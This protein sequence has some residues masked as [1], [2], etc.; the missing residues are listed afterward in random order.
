MPITADEE[1]R[2]LLGSVRTIAVLGAKADPGEDANHV[3]LY[4]QRQG[5]EI[6]PVNPKLAGRTVLG[7][8]AVGRLADAGRPIDLVDVFRA[9]DHVPGHVDEILALSPRPR[10]VWLQLGIRHR[11]AT[12]RLEAAGVRVVEDRC[13]MVDHRRLFGA[14]R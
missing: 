10:A 2:A 7:E 3:P 8:T 11:D 12:E 5:Y 9:S 14:G 1:L 6:V 13:I 4:L